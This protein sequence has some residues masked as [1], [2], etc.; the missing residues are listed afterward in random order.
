M[1]ARLRTAWTQ[2]GFVWSRQR[3]DEHTR[4]E[5]EA[6]LDLLAERYVE[7]GLS[8]DEARRAARRQFGSVATI[9][10]EIRDLNSLRL[11][12]QAGQDL[13][14]A[15]RQIRRAPGFAAVVIATLGLGIGATTAVFSVV[16]AVLLTPLPYDEPGQLVRFHQYRPDQPDT[17]DVLA[18]THFV[19]LREHTASFEDVAALAHYSETGLDL[20]V[21]G[22]A[23]RL[24]VLRVSSGYFSTLRAQPRL[25]QGFERD[26]ETGVRKVVLSDA[27]WRARFDANPSIVGRSVLLSAEPYEVVGVAPPGFE[28]P[29]APD[30]AAWIPYNLARDTYEENNSLT[31]IGRLRKGIGIPRAQAELDAL[32]GPMRE[33][34]PAAAKSA[35][36]ATP[37]HE[38]LVST[39]RTPLRLVFAAAALVLLIACVNVANLVLVRATGRTH[40]LAVRSALGSSRVRLI[41]Q[42]LVENAL[43]A[44]LGG[45]AGLVVAMV[46]VRGLQ[47][48][49]AHALPRLESIGLDPHVLLFAL[50][51]TAFSVVVFG[52]APSLRLANVHPTDAFRQQ[53]R[54]TTG[55][56]GL[57]RLRGALVAGQMAL[58]LALVAGAG[59]LLASFHQ[60]QQIDP[61]IDA[62]GVLT[63]DVH[64][65]TARY[66]VDRRVA[67]QEELA[68]RLEALPGV[69]SA[70]G[71]SRLPVTGTY[72]PWNAHIRT[73]PLAGTVVDRGRF[74]LQQRTVSG[75]VFEALGIPIV[76]GRTFDDRDDVSA[77][78]RAVVSA[79]FARQAFPGLPY[80]AVLGQR[81][82]V[83]GRD[84]DII[85]IVGDVT[86]DVY[87]TPTMAVYQAHR[88]FGSNRNWALVQ[89]VAG[90]RTTADTLAAVRTEMARLDAELVVHRPTAM[91][92]VLG[93]G[94]SRER[95]ALVLMGAFAVAALALAALGLYG[96]LAYTV[97]QRTTE[98]GIRLALGATP[99]QVRGLVFRQAVLVVS[100]GLIAGLA[101]ALVAGR[102]LAA[103]TF[104]ISPSDPRVLAATVLAVSIPALVAAWLPARRAAR[105]P[106][107]VALH[108]TL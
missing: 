70:G 38:E 104:Q 46:S 39:A 49:G 89:V 93:R 44:A 11:V 63:F 10:R 33:R 73:G 65:P 94:A 76:A 29:V 48:L 40:E 69:R 92:D 26:D 19:F 45:V 27:V 86:L 20:S 80:E 21:N 13:R 4:L 90:D 67:F 14:Y 62:R 58:A 100:I 78:N 35:I 98:I 31:A 37:L 61:G 8:P 97:R 74:A 87:G 55:G 57:A 41:R 56:R 83:A 64:L 24:R 15:S 32:S 16:Q 106:P 1:L 88:Q 77:P 25:G 42:L 17:R 23:E 5:V 28:D 96:M 22:R 107:A 108:D 34:W 79:S 81:I 95:F 3:E 36:L 30:V 9:Q 101:G 75:H 103:M 71:I 47:R 2:L 91:A 68:R 53:S 54:S 50:V 82:G 18:G 60:L 6:H 66:D 105:V 102:W 52:V 72:H 7:Q 85:G 43:L 84:L 99:G 59:V 12:E 51:A